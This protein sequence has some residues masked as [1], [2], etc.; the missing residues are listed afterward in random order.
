MP[1]LEP[2]TLLTRGAVA[3]ALTEAGF[4]TAP[5]TLATKATR[6]GGPPYRKWATRPLY[7]WGEA[8]A[9]ARDRLGPTV[10]STSEAEPIRDRSDRAAPI[11]PST[12][13]IPAPITPEFEAHGAG[14]APPS[15][16]AGA[17]PIRRRQRSRQIPQK[18]SGEKLAD[19]GF[20]LA[21]AS[22][23]RGQA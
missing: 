11:A 9:W 22:A 17:T 19:I 14:V 5:A 8:L 23:K 7:P 1:N 4:P 18:K 15:I 10:R 20:P 16:T 6:G 21:P 2:D 3:A 13:E 12:V